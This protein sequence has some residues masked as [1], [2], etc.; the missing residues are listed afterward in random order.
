MD[1]RPARPPAAS[2]CGVAGPRGGRWYR[3]TT[4]RRSS[5]AFERLGAD[6]RSCPSTNSSALDGLP[7]WDLERV[8]L[9]ADPPPPRE[10]GAGAAQ[11]P[12]PTPR[13]GTTWSAPPTPRTS[14]CGG[15]GPQ[16]G[17]GPVLDLGCGTGRVGL[18]LARKGSRC[19]RRGLRARA[20]AGVHAP[21]PGR[22]PPG[23]GGGR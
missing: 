6:G 8:D 3:A 12:W 20:R 19:R 1:L 14:G 11:S 21:G 10:D 15:G 17:G 18:H 2:G 4:S 16:W 7:V 23:P 22:E 5:A 13:L 9:P